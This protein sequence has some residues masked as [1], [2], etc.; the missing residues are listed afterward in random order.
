ML[1]TIEVVFDGTAFVPSEPVDLPA[2]TRLSLTVPQGLAGT[3]SQLIPSKPRPLTE[4][5][6]KKWDELSR[7][8]QSSPPLFS[9]IEEEMAYIRGR[10]WPELL[11]APDPIELKAQ[12]E[13]GKEGAG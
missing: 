10:P 8:W 3:P 4:E 1:K 5:E 12:E 13:I 6:K 7:I 2:G 9:S 11:L